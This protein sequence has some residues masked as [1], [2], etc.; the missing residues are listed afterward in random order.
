LARYNNFKYGEEKYGERSSR[1]YSVEPFLAYAI[2]YQQ[3]YLTYSP[4]TGPFTMVRIVRNQYAYSETQNDGIVI[5]ESTT[6]PADRIDTFQ[7]ASGRFAFYSIWIELEDDSWVLAGETEVLIPAKHSSRIY[8]KYIDETNTSVPADILLQTTHERFLDYIPK[9]FTAEQSI[10]D[11]QNTDNDL[12]LFLEGFSFTVDEFLT[13]TQLVLPGLSGKYSNAGILR[14]QGNQLG[15]PED[16]QGLTKTQKYLVRDAV[17]TYSRKGTAAGLNRF[18][19]AITGYVPTITVSSNLL[20]SIQD[21]TFYKGTG[22]WKGSVGVLVSAV[23]TS[24]VPTVGSNDLVVDDSW[25]L[26][27]DTTEAVSPYPEVYL[28]SDDPILTGVPVTAGV[29]YTFSYWIKKDSGSGNIFGQSIKWFDQTGKRV[30]DSPAFE[31]STIT[32]SWVRKTW[33]IT[34][35]SKAVFASVSINFSQTSGVYYM[36]RVQFAV[37]SETN[38]S[39][40]RAIKIAVASDAVT[41]L[42]K[43]PRL[44]FEIT[45]YLPINKA[46]F[47]TSSSGFESSGISS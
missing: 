6:L 39:E 14:L 7:L 9:V 38:Y 24:A 25:I 36:D 47:I 41:R 31:T 20:L 17:Y 26:K 8:P 4:P 42:V 21:S 30:V 40:A 32:T 2:D 46:Y 43:I 44:N 22:N 1:Q 16:T 33:T 23:N 3:V 15:V 45:R 18:V 34:A 35:P 37:S 27:V 28:G 5:L 11:N 12:S 13:Y 19:K 29:E 10:L